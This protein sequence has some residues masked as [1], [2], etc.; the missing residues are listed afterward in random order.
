M[1]TKLSSE[2]ICTTRQTIFRFLK[3]YNL[4][5][6]ISNL[7]K[8]GRSAKL[9]VKHF[10]FIDKCY[11]ENDEY[12]AVDIQKRHLH[13]FNINV[14]VT[15]IKKV[16]RKLGWIETGPKYCQAIRPLNCEKRLAFCTKLLADEEHFNDVMFTDKSSIE[17]NRHAVRCFRKKG[18]AP[19]MKPKVK[20]P[21]KVH[22]CGGIS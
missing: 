11:N 13:S 7:E 2:G 18:E 5:G 12:S 15:T 6:K 4:S 8:S 19:K 3:K 1:L 14:S 17:I 10:N 22:V 20:H 21:Y 9:S 16:R